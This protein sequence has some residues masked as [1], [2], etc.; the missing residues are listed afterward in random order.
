M[1]LPQPPKSVVAE[2]VEKGKPEP[3]CYTLG[4]RRIGLGEEAR[5]TGDGGPRLLVVEDAPSGVRAGRAAGCAVV[6]LATTHTVASLQTAG[7]DWIVRD[8]QTLR[9]TESPKVKGTTSD[10]GAAEHG[11]KDGVDGWE[12]RILDAWVGR[13]SVSG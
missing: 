10:A 8:L 13:T 1:S 6:A 4:R 3:E 12:V 7:A 11:S 9:L 5:A 2:D